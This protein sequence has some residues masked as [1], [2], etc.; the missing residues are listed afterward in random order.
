MTTER[1]QVQVPAVYAFY[2]GT[3]LSERR[4]E[5]EAMRDRCMQQRLPYPFEICDDIYEALQHALLRRLNP[6]LSLAKREAPVIVIGD[7]AAIRPLRGVSEDPEGIWKRALFLFMRE[8][9]MH[10]IPITGEILHKKGGD[11]P[12]FERAYLYLKDQLLTRAKQAQ[13]AKPG[14]LNVQR[15][16]YGY[17]GSGGRL[18]L[19]HEKTPVIRYVIQ[20]IMQG[21]TPTSVANGLRTDESLWLTLYPGGIPENIR[22]GWDCSKIFRI[23]G[24]IRLYCLGEFVPKDE[25]PIIL[26]E[27]AFLPPEWARN[28]SF[29]RPDYKQLSLFPELVSADLSALGN[30]FLHDDSEGPI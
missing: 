18:I 19:D 10:L 29:N 12:P 26:P 8:H 1:A 17:T 15:P 5:V 28:A 6:R 13:Q 9:R 11:F 3:S 30:R 24:N 7:E 2:S 14:S 16:P 27:L 4:Q 23:C 22:R 25:T 21:R 20:Q